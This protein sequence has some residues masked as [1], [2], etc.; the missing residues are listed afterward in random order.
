MVARPSPDDRAD[1]ADGLRRAEAKEAQPCET[2]RGFSLLYSLGDRVVVSRARGHI[3]APHIEALMAYCDRRLI[4]APSLFVVHDWFGV[5]SY[6]SR[7][8]ILMT[9]WARATRDQHEAIHIGVRSR[10]VRMGI[11]V[12]A[13]ASGGPITTHESVASLGAA[14][15]RGL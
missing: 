14:L 12:V 2:D 13:L 3:D 7:V 10:L 9:P 8:R 11:S 4:V 5:T 6:D 1:F 15:D